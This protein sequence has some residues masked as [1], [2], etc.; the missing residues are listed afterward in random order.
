MLTIEEYIEKR[1]QEDKLNEFDLDK[2]LENIKSCID[3]IFEYYNNYLDISEIDQ[4]TI[5]NNERL[6]KYRKQLSKYS[7]NIKDW[8]VDTYDKHGN[9][10]NKIIGNILD[11][12][13]LF[14]AMST[15]GEFRSISYEYYSGLIKKYPFLSGKITAWLE[16]TMEKYGVNIEAFVY[17]YLNKFFD[18]DDMWPRTHKKRVENSYRKYD[19][20]YTKKTNLFG[21][22]LLYPKI[23][24]KPYIKGKKQYI[25]ILMMYFWLK[26]FEGDNGYWDKYLEMIF[27]KDKD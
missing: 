14:L 10:M 3:Y 18:N 13:E 2:R 4:K 20:D 16:D 17:S 12:N 25:E 7:D 19:N 9:C 5:L 21:I 23:S 24:S 27:S 26:E 11:E 8:L 1:K 15:D 6:N 22:D